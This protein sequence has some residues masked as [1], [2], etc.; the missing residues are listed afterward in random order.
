MQAGMNTIGMLLA[1]L[2]IN[3]IFWVTI[4]PKEI[5][6]D[7]DAHERVK[8]LLG[9]RGDE[10]GLPLDKTGTH[11]QKLLGKSL[12]DYVK[13][14]DI[15]RREI[16]AEMRTWSDGRLEQYFTIDDHRI[17][18]AWVLYHV[19]E[20]VAAHLGQISLLKHIMRDEGILAAPDGT[21]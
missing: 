18:H 20:H 16:H 2:A 13:M 19:L 21:D 1:H 14:L 3:L 10:D 7:P 8:A 11:P 4:A 9:I 15:A 6:V 5:P 17:S 12:D